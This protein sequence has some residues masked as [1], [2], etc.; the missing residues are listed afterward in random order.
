MDTIADSTAI[1]NIDSVEQPSL[2]QLFGLIDQQTG[3]TGRN[4]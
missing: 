2:E 3:G 1:E 4:R